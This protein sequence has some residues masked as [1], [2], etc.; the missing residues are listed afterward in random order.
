LENALH[1]WVLLAHSV[2]AFLNNS[3]TSSLLLKKGICLLWID[4]LL[5]L[6]SGDLAIEV[7]HLV[8]LLALKDL[9][10]LENLSLKK[11]ELLITQVL[12]NLVGD[13]LLIGDVIR[14]VVDL[15]SST[16]NSGIQGH[17]VLRRVL[18]VLFE[19]GNLPGQSTLR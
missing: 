18:Q 9:L 10:L 8:E 7:A 4:L 11:L 14:H 19:I 16:L 15:I 5:E 2:D 12:S 6:T 1:L 13:L 3:I 17:G